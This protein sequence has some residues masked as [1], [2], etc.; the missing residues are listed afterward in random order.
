MRSDSP[1]C[2]KMRLRP[3]STPDP[4]VGTYSSPLDPQLDLGEGKECEREGRGKRKGG[5]GN[6][7]GGKGEESDVLIG[8]VKVACWC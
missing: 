4:A 5:K 1:K 7:R 3:G 6:E 8:W 2:V